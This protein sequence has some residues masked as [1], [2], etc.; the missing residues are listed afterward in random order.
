MT[1]KYIAIIA[2]SGSKRLLNKNILSLCGKPLFV[3]SIIAAQQTSKIERILV[4][5]DSYEYQQIA[6][7][8]GAEC[9]T[10]EKLIYLETMS[11]CRCSKSVL[12]G[13]GDSLTS[14]MSLILLQPT[15]PL[16]TYQDIN[17]AIELYEARQASAVVSVTELECSP[18]GPVFFRRPVNGQ[19]FVLYI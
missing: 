7:N 17:N 12:D 3:W 15:S 9:P 19:F 1:N 16:R 5:T 14:D 8:A 2:R 11:V 13:I 6:I 4:S 10:L 18:N